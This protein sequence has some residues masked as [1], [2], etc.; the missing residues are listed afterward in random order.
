MLHFGTQTKFQEKKALKDAVEHNGGQVVYTLSRKTSLFVCTASDLTAFKVVTAVK[1]GVPVVSPVFLH[2][3]IREGRVTTAAATCAFKRFTNNVAMQYLDP[4]KFLLVGATAS[5]KLKS[6][7]LDARK[8]AKGTAAVKPYH[9]LHV[10]LKDHHAVSEADPQ[11]AAFEANEYV[12]ARHAC[13]TRDTTDAVLFWSIEIDLAPND[14]ARVFTHRGSL[15]K[16][17]K[18]GAQ[19]IASTAR[20]SRFAADVEHAEAL[21]AELYHQQ[22]EKVQVFLYF[23]KKN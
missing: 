17:S 22:I 21:Y 8:S 16:L 7:I 9:Q 2:E 12:V 11:H 13:F 5:D 4:D 23:L 14:K 10:S 19:A 15:S 20:E 1:L 18:Q 6:G 3:C